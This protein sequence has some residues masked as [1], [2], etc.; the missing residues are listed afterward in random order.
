MAENFTVCVGKEVKEFVVI[1]SIATRS[2]KFFQAAMSRDWKEALEKRVMLPETEVRVFEGYLQWLYTGD[3]TLSQND[4]YE[5]IELYILGDF[6]DDAK[7]RNSLLD[8]LMSGFHDENFVPTALVVQLAWDKTPSD[9]WLRQAILELWS[10]VPFHQAIA[11]LL[12]PNPEEQMYPREF[13]QLHFQRIESSDGLGKVKSS[14]K[15]RK[16]IAAD[17]MLRLPVT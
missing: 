13:V 1:K 3:L 4:L 11:C 5:E 14:K 12:E 2:S 9:S 17:F 7:F 6:L 15:S 8:S 16:Q 10:T